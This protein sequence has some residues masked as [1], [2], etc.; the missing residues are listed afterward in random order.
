MSQATLPQDPDIERILTFWF[1][2]RYASTRWFTQS[3]TLDQQIRAQFGVL[4]AKARTPDLDHWCQTPQG[5]LALVILLDQFS[6]NVH[7]GLADSYSADAKAMNVTTKAIAQ[8]F[9]G[10]VSLI[11]QSFFYFPLMHSETLLGQ[12]AAKGMYEA[13]ALRC[14][15]GDIKT[16]EF[17]DVSVGLAQRHINVIVKFGRF[18]ARNEALGRESTAEEVVFLKEH[19]HGH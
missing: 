8:G 12:V 7:R 17:A 9:D 16:E 4:V 19:P 13:L 3:D 18:P 2:D 5:S 6:R 15:G 14:K 1:H 11:R 10:K